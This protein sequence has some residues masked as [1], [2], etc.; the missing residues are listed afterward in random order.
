[1]HWLLTEGSS[2]LCE[3]I[4]TGTNALMIAINNGRFPATQ[5]PLERNAGPALMAVRNKYLNKAWHCM[6]SNLT[7]GDD[8]LSS[9]LKVMV[10]LKDAPAYVISSMSS[11][12]GDICTRGRLLWVQLPS[13]QE[14]Q[15]ATVV[16]HCPLPA[17]LQSLVAEYAA[18]TP[19]TMWAGGLRVQ[20]TRAKRARRSVEKE[21]DDGGEDVPL[22]RRSLRLRQK[23]AKP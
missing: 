11:K 6:G 5:Y 20:V 15:R 16:T 9:L 7:E 1:M 10:M 18:T 17:V 3:I 2:S 21:E 13:Y 22:L 4:N 8:E 23:R 19:E 14:Q 12:N